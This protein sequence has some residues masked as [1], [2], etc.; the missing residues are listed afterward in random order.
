MYGLS[1]ED[2]EIQSRARAFVDEV[3]PYEVEAEMNHG[4]LPIELVEAQRRR[5]EELGLGGTNIPK[6]FGGKGFSFLQQVLVQEQCGRAT[7]ALGWVVHTPALWFTKVATPEQL[8]RWLAPSI[9][10]ETRECYAI[11]EEGAGSDVDAIEAT[12]RRDGDEYVLNGVKWHVTSYNDSQYVFFQA[13]LTEGPHAGEHA[14]F[15]V[16]LPHPGISVVRTPAYTHTFSHHHPIVAFEDVRV[17]IDQRIGDEGGGMAFAYDWFRYERLMIA[18][19]CLGA[20]ER[21]IEAG[22]LRH[23]AVCRPR[24]DVRDRSRDRC[25][26][27]HQGP[28]RAVLDDQA[29]RIGDGWA[30]RRPFG[31]DLR[32]ARVHARERRRAVLPR[33]AGRADLGGHLGDPAGDHRRPASQARRPHPPLT[34]D[35]VTRTPAPISAT[36]VPSCH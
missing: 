12:A 28:A 33:A 27:R 34:R 5:V 29:V 20:A 35:P 2:L 6:S 22:G 1:A 10:G 26:H 3:I 25:R 14:M 13:K 9:R 32:R 4:E 31:P 24:D 18:A 16:D 15:V 36:W 8:D 30:R 7:N 21:L 11:T 19:R 23:R 17:P